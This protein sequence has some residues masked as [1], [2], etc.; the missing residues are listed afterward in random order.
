MSRSEAEP[1]LVELERI[2][3]LLED[4]LAAW[5]RRCLKAESDVEDARRK[6]EA[7]PAITSGDMQLRERRIGELEEENATLRRR[8]EAAREQLEQLRTRLRFVGDQAMGGVR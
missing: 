2:A 1:S 7:V 3:A 4:E 8:I 6:A 5:R